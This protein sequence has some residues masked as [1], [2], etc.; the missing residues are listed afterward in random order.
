MRRDLTLALR[1]LVRRPGAALVAVMTVATGVA[2][3]GAILALVDTILLRP[4]TGVAAP[5]RVMLIART[6]LG[7]GWDNASYPNLE[8]ANEM[9]TTFSAIAAFDGSPTNIAWNRGAA[10]DSITC[11]LVSGEYFPVLGTRPARGRLLA[12]ADD[13]PSQTEVPVVVSFRFWTSRLDSADDVVGTRLVLNGHSAAIV[14]VAPDGFHGLGFEPPDLWAPIAF[15]PVLITRWGDMLSSRGS[16]WLQ[17]V[18]RLTDDAAP[19][20]AIADIQRI[21]DVLQKAYPE[22]NADK[23]LTAA[24]LAG[25]PGLPRGP[26]FLFLGTLAAVAGLVFVVACTN[27]AGVLLARIADRDREMAVRRALGCGHGGIIRLVLVD[28]AI[29]FA[30]GTAIGLVAS[31]WVAAALG[32]LIAS[33]PGGLVIAPVVGLR[34]VAVMLGLATV[35]GVLCG[36]VPTAAVLRLGITPSLGDT[37]GGPGPG[38]ART[39][40]LLLAAQVATCLVLLVIA[41]LFGRSLQRASTIDPGFEPRGLDIASFDLSL[42]GLG[43]DEAVAVI[44][45]LLEGARSLPQVTSAAV[46]ADLPLDL[47]GIGF[48]G[49]SAVGAEPV[50]GGTFNADWN[51]ITPDYFE[52]MKIEIVSGRAFGDGDNGR[53]APVAI[54]NQTLA[55]RFWPG[56]DAVGKTLYNGPVG[57]ETTMTVVGVARDHAYR[58]LGE[59]P[60]LFVYVPLEQMVNSRLSLI[61]RRSSDVTTVPD[62]RTLVARTAPGV[63]VVDAQPLVRYIGISLAPQ[64]LATFVTGALGALALLLVTV[65]VYGT[66]ATVVSGRRREMGIRI[67]L[68]AR[69][70]ELITLVLAEALKLSAWGIVAGA[71]IAIAASQAVRSLLVAVGPWDPVAFVVAAVLLLVMVMVGSAVPA[72]RAARVNAASSLRHT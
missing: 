66:T 39:R 19:E 24:S 63:P 33:L 43:G 28:T 13:D 25:A 15:Q 34:V 18:G 9:S 61:V 50:D 71:A 57:S 5:D 14:G 31:V 17:G 38:R 27:V 42:A 62:L 6:D 58:A 22:A 70:R 11:S 30:L 47:G 35:G 65:G 7:D 3:L 67:A 56:E 37:L 1:H 60:R 20:E 16:V 12:S 23:G 40:R 49:I 52:T 51:A 45:Q 64:R 59:A 48:G 26:L 55:S 2:G 32:H 41:S 68:G 4:P 53:A 46:A 44:G 72:I 8:D 10:T 29:L 36:V 21:G 54:V 69:P